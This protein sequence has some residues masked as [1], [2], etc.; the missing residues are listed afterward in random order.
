MSALLDV[1]TNRDV[2]IL[3]ELAICRYL[4]VDQLRRLFFPNASLD[5]VSQRMRHLAA[6]GLVRNVRYAH[7]GVTRYSY[8]HVTSLALALCHTLEPEGCVFR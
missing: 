1:L 7:D 2:E 8:W 4:R 5:R 3:R 6:R